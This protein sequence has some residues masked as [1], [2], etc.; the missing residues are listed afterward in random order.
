LTFQ[1]SQIVEW[2]VEFSSQFGYFGIFLISLVGALSIFLPIPYT[3][4]IFILGGYQLDSGIYVFD[5]ILIAVVA[6][7]GSVVGEF[8][9]Y[10]IG[11][12]G[13][14]VISQRYQ[15]K[16][17][18]MVR[19]FK[20]FGPIVIFLFALTPLPDD[21]LFIPLGV[22][23]YSLIRAFIPAFIGKVCMSYVVAYGGRYSIQILQD[24]FGVEST[25]LSAIIGMIIA[26]VLLVI[27]FVVMFKLDWE[28][29]V[30]R[31]LDKNSKESLKSN[32]PT[33]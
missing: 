26:I 9:G 7:L 6:G 15:K 12:G 29:Y 11:V 22:I 24:I 30:E 16:M 31:Y 4:V 27:I 20:R 33:D 21:L 10:L 13:R 18:L 17:D 2:M 14:R 5:P 23:N 3:V 28:K 25:F 32:D 8:S 1:L 19:L